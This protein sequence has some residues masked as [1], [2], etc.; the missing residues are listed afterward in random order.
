MERLVQQSILRP[1][2][3]RD[4]PDP[5]KWFSYAGMLALSFFL[6]YALALRD[7][8]DIS[9]HATWAGEG[10]FSQPRT[11]LH[12]GAHPLWH[13]LVAAVMR[14][15]LPVKQS[16]AL[17][18]AVLKTLEL[19]LIRRLLA[20]CIRDVPHPWVLTAGAVCCSVAASLCI[21]WINPTVYLGIGSPNTW[22][23]PTQMIA[24]V[25]MLLCVPYAAYCYGEFERL[26]LTQGKATVLPWRHVALLS[27]LLLTSL[28][29]KPTFMQTFLPAAGIFV[30]VQFVR[31]P[32]NKRFFMQ[33]VWAI[34]P[35][36]LF[37]VLQF[38]FYFSGVLVPAQGGITLEITPEKVAHVLLATVLIQAFPIYVACTCLTKK[39][40]QDPL[41]ALTL[42]MDAVGIGEWLLLGETGRRA[43]DGNFGW[44]MMGGAL[45][46][47]VVAMALFLRSHYSSTMG[48]HSQARA[49]W[50]F[51][52]GIVLLGWHVAS[53]IYYI[54]YLFTTTNA[55]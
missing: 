2:G 49:R 47:W 16:A 52:I 39:D 41:V 51:P 38:L 10:V 8:S 50:Q 46:L 7:G 35:S 27:L 42:L 34:L 53:G 55:L 13:V 5:W 18:T 12:H 15:G 54:G 48:S 3:H 6:F 36:V 14:V 44:G 1:I 29:A 28:V 11:F 45:M 23:S 30:L 9:I 33:L 25:A 26:R 31:H 37:M 40:L 17:V 22:H 4:R 19:A 43:G 21:P 24:M 32:E 20:L